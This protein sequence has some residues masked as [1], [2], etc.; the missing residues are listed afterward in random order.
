M[1]HVLIVEE[2]RAVSEVIAASLRHEVD[3]DVIGYAT[4]LMEAGSQLT[5]CDVV[6]INAALHPQAHPPLIRTIR[7]LAPRVKVFVMGLS[8]DQHLLLPYI[9][10]G[11][12]GY[13]FKDDP[14]EELLKNLRMT[15]TGEPL[16]EPNGNVKLMPHLLDMIGLDQLSDHDCGG[17]EA[18]TRREWEV[19]GLIQ[20]GQTNQ[21]IAQ[22]L[23]IE[24]GTAK[25]HVHNILRKLKVNSRRDAAHVSRLVGS[26]S[27]KG[28]KMVAHPTYQSVP[29]LG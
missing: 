12:A 20:Q 5:Q 1:V 27:W 21:E 19:L 6:L 2:V 28:E 22:A 3:I 29:N 4:N 13:T 24:L 8:H 23:V 7:Q 18:L 11:V 9:L 16:R 14:F 25:N 10:A 17:P 26:R 15:Q